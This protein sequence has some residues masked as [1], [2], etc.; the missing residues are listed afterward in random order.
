MLKL[1][2]N[3]FVA[4]LNRKIK[5]KFL[6]ASVENTNPYNGFFVYFFGGLECV[7]PS[8]AYVSH[9]VF[10]RD[11]WIRTQKATVASRRAIRTRIRIFVTAYFSVIDRFY[12]VYICTKSAFGSIFMISDGFRNNFLSPGRYLELGTSFLKWISAQDFQ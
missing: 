2:L 3:I 12:Q 9:F 4:F 11:V 1:F 5:L 7:R 10:L 6:F 8:F